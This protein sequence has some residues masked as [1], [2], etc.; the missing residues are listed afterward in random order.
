[1]LVVI[2]IGP[3]NE[4]YENLALSLCALNFFSAR[5]LRLK[6]AERRSERKEKERSRDNPDC[7]AKLHLRALHTGTKGKASH[8]APQKFQDVHTGAFPYK[9]NTWRLKGHT[10]GTYMVQQHQVPMRGAR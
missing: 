3:K 6:S 10:K 5:A 8:P 1:M 9:I 4:R 7:T 2:I